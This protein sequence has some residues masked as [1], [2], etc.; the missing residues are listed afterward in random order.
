MKTLVLGLGNP[1]LTDD[2]IGW[3]VANELASQFADDEDVEVRQCCVGGLRLMEEL[4]G[5]DAAVIIDAVCSGAVPG[6]VQRF[7]VDDL[8]TQ[9]SA[10][11]HDA[12]LPMA[13]QLG[14]QAGANLPAD[15]S[16]R[17]I[18]VEAMDVTT[19]GEECTR[20]L[21]SAI[22]AATE[23]AAQAVAAVQDST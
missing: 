6:A 2:G 16:I 5:F 17:L 13:L 14:R 4:V 11:A 21:R 1:V 15:H 8:P 19:F 20:A 3:H 9:H 10:S 7:E 23:A 12:S 18:G 22:P